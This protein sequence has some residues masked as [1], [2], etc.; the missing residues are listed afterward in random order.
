MFLKDAD[1]FD[2]VRVGDLGPAMLQLAASGGLVVAEEL[3]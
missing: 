3:Y 1:G 2:R